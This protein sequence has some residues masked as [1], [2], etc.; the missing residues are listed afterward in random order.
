MM[1]T[2]WPEHPDDPVHDMAAGAALLMIERGQPAKGVAFYNRW[3]RLA[4]Y[5]E[6]RL[7][8]DSPVTIDMSE[9]GIVCVLGLGSRGMEMLLCQ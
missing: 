9:D 1:E 4:G 7:V 5:S 3:A 6:I 2:Q 8:S